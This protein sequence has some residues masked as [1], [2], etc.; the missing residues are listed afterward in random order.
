[1]MRTPT[2]DWHERLRTRM[3]ELQ[4]S[5]AD[6]ARSTGLSEGSMSQ[7]LS[8]RTQS[9]KYESIR[10][11]CQ[12]L[13]TPI[14]WILYGERTTIDPHDQ[15]T[16]RVRGFGGVPVLETVSV[17]DNGQVETCARLKGQNLSVPGPVTSESV[18]AVRLQGDA[19][20]SPM[21]RH[22]WC[23]TIDPEHE[24]VPGE[25]HLVTLTDGNRYLRELLW[26]RDHAISLLSLAPPHERWTVQ[27]DEVR[28]IELVTS[29][30]S[31]AALG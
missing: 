12:F 18:Y 3:Q 25:L 21:L 10:E 15:L 22:G 4:V 7:W 8:G 28:R 20:A 31:P 13:R 30:V 24:P 23:L 2:T 6:L 19:G 29:L 1:M 11:V 14:D 26:L 16:A 27:R 9:P 17:A 5:A